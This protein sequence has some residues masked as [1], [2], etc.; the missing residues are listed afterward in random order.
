MAAKTRMYVKAQE[1]S[2]LSEIHSSLR[3]SKRTSKKASRQSSK[4]DSASDF[5]D[6]DIEA[7]KGYSAFSGTFN[8]FRYG[9]INSKMVHGGSSD[10]P[11]PVTQ[12]YNPGQGSSLDKDYHL[13]AYSRPSEAHAEDAGGGD[14]DHRFQLGGLTASSTNNT[15]TS[16]GSFGHLGTLGSVPGRKATLPWEADDDDDD[17]DFG[18]VGQLTLP[19]MTM[20]ALASPLGTVPSQPRTDQPRLD[21]LDLGSVPPFIPMGG[22]APGSLGSLPLGTVP[23]FPD[24][25]GF[26]S[27]PG[28]AP[29]E[30]DDLTLTSTHRIS[31]NR[32]SGVTSSDF[33]EVQGFQISQIGDRADHPG[34][35]MSD[36]GGLRAEEC[37]GG[38]FPGVSALDSNL[39]TDIGAALRKL[40]PEDV[41][42]RRR[43]LGRT[44]SYDLGSDGFDSPGSSIFGRPGFNFLPYGFIPNLTTPRPTSQ[45]VIMKSLIC[46]LSILSSVTW[47]HRGSYLYYTT[48]DGTN[49]GT[50]RVL[51]AARNQGVH[52]TFFV[53]GYHLDPTVFEPPSAEESLKY[54]EQVV[55]E[56]HV[57]GDHTYDHLGHNQQ[58]SYLSLDD[59]AYFGEMN[60]NALWQAMNQTEEL[61]SKLEILRGLVRMPFTNNWRVNMTN[62]HK[63][64]HHNCY[65]CTVPWE[66]SLLAMEIADILQ[67][68]GAR[69]MGWDLEWPSD[70]TLGLLDTAE[71]ML[72]QLK[73]LTSDLIIGEANKIVLLNHDHGFITHPDEAQSE[74]EKFF[75]EA[76]A[77]GFIFR[78]MDTYHTD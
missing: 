47:A 77:A 2:L 37:K 74:L 20:E 23:T 22:P 68:Q 72:E 50:P 40:K 42:H 3:S 59:L 73:T 15:L 70:T 75:R 48:D 25:R 14:R 12:G 33:S 76:K 29:V 69:V 67:A 64:L 53:N 1:S 28:I 49:P 13:E 39:G 44:Y 24:G 58:Y 38:E 60:A 57:L 54:M 56:G 16:A 51:A 21:R 4:L 45:S 17:P 78:T 8:T 34:D 32:D 36:D 5:S 27:L 61:W 35:G 65:T 62:G 19:Q 30:D 31:L 43:Q 41:E 6:S 46:T 55:A 9:T 18:T 7:R 11:V 66:S 63:D 52:V 71:N 10:S 26:C